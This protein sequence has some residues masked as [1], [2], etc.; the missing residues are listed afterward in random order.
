MLELGP[1]SP[2]FY[3]PHK[4]EGRRRSMNAGVREEKTRRKLVGHCRK[5]P[6]KEEKSLR[7][8]KDLKRLQGGGPRQRVLRCRRDQVLSWKGLHCGG[9]GNAGKGKGVLHPKKAHLALPSSKSMEASLAD[10]ENRGDNSERG[11]REMPVPLKAVALKINHDP[12]P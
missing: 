9:R 10:Q 12:Y 5:H 2:A 7:P 6:S 3:L 1:A 11:N 4:L 8:E